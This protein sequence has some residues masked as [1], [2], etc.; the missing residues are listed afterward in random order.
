MRFEMSDMLD[1]WSVF[2]DYLP[3]KV[4]ENA[5]TDYLKFMADKG[6]DAAV[7]GE[8]RGEDPILDK[9]ADLVLED[10]NEGGSEYYDED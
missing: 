8:I 2:R 4:R 10:E 9:V 3:A 1:V 6:V 7:F 5:A